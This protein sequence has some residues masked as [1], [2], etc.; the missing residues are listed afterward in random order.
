MQKDGKKFYMESLDLLCPEFSRLL[1]SVLARTRGT[2]EAQDNPSS[3]DKT[4]FCK[5]LSARKSV[6]RDQLFSTSAKSWGCQLK[7]GGH[8]VQKALFYIAKISAEREIPKCAL[9][10]FIPCCNALSPSILPN[11]AL[12]IIFNWWAR[13]HSWC[14]SREMW[15]MSTQGTLSQLL[16]PFLGECGGREPAACPFLLPAVLCFH[17]LCF[18]YRKSHKNALHQTQVS[19]TLEC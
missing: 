17:K 9:G 6:N 11:I 14:L 15:E 12:R 18:S 7:P 13:H 5:I 2:T 10:P 4:Q 16:R 1:S 3:W 19:F 8:S